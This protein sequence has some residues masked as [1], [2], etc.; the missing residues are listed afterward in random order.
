MANNTPHVVG[1]GARSIARA[2]WQKRQNLRRSHH[3][4][5]IHAIHA[6]ATR[7]AAPAEKEA[8]A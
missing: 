6:A 4:A 8:A 2:E 1:Q 5:W 7:T 3:A